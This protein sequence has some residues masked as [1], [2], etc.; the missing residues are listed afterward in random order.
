MKVAFI[1]RDGT[2]VFEPKDG[3]VRPDDLRILPGVIEG[4]KA[5]KAAGYTIVMVT[6][7]DFA[8]SAD[9]AP[10]FDQTQI[11]LKDILKK[12]GIVFDQI[13]LCPHSPGAGCDC[14]KPK[15]GMVTKFLSENNIDKKASM[16]IGDRP[17]ADGG[18]AENIGVRYVK[19]GPSGTFTLPSLA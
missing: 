19:V 10:F 13:F 18:L 14:R 15:P 6:N 1:D 2:L 4:L 7:Q 17:E 3:L 11:M 16:V 5:L 9:H 8:K 12:E